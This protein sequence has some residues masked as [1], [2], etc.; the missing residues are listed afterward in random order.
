MSLKNGIF[1]VIENNEN[2]P[3]IRNHIFKHSMVS[4]LLALKSLN[5]LNQCI[6][7][8]HYFYIKVL[9]SNICRLPFFKKNQ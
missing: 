7:M 6:F 1:E 2:P 5:G 8:H 9:K 4:F 3:F